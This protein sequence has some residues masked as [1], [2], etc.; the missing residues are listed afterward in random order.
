M[1]EVVTIISK[2]KKI[3]LVTIIFTGVMFF[4]VGALCVSSGLIHTET[5]KEGLADSID[6]SPDDQQIIFSYYQNGIASL[7]TANVDG[8]DVK[9]LTGMKGNSLLRP[10]YSTDSKKIVFITSPQYKENK[11]QSLF[12]MDRDGGNQKQLTPQED[13]ITEAI[14]SPDSHNIYFLKAGIFKNYSPIASK[15]P[16]EFDIFSVG[17]DGN[18][19]KRLTYE[20]GYD[21]SSLSITS[22]GQRLLCVKYG[23]DEQPLYISSVDGKET[24]YK[25]LPKENIGKPWIYYAALSPDNQSVTFSA[26][27]E[28]SKDTTYEYELYIMNLKTYE[29]EQLTKLQ[30]HVSGPVFFH[31]QN[32]IMFLQNYN[33]PNNP[34]KYQIY[35]I[36]LNTKELKKINLDIDKMKS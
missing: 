4:L 13:L 2:R 33:W 27:S 30:S 10:K 3:I 31:K 6:I 12:V 5:K 19:L 7:Y 32:K 14:F 18:N 8:T 20:K 29:A 16:H 34:P 36:D 11:Q 22:D 17:V 15:R 9:F 35:T 21:M 23:N 28:S 1:E 26:V 25:I 24:L